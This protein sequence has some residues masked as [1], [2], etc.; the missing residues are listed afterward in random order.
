[1]IKVAVETGDE[2]NPPFPAGQ[3]DQPSVKVQLALGGANQGENVGVQGR[4]VETDPGK[5]V[6]W[7]VG[8]DLVEQCQ[9]R[10]PLPVCVV[11]GFSVFQSVTASRHRAYQWLELGEGLGARWLVNTRL[12]QSSMLANPGYRDGDCELGVLGEIEWLQRAQ[13]PLLVYHWNSIVHHHNLRRNL[14]LFYH[15]PP[16]KAMRAEAFQVTSEGVTHPAGENV[17]HYARRRLHGWRAAVA[18]AGP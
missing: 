18:G 15:I 5:R 4:Y 14:A 13:D 1:M 10:Y 9:L 16:N 6:R 17:V 8:D 2:W 11:E 7:E 12:R 3:S